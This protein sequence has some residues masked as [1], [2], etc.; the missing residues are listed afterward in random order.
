MVHE[1][2]GQTVTDGTIEK[3]SCHGGVDTS[4][5]AEDDPILP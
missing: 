1:D 2:T 5:E 3:D 4:G